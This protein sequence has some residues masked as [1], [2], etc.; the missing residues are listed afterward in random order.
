MSFAARLGSDGMA[1]GGVAEALEEHA[2]YVWLVNGLAPVVGLGLL[3]RGLYVLRDPRPV[4]RNRADRVRRPPHTDLPLRAVYGYADRRGYYRSRGFFRRV[5]ATAVVHTVI[6]AS[7]L[8]MF[9]RGERFVA[10]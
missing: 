10:G 3:L 7:L 8:L 2:V 5:V 4:Q 9:A 1:D 6:G